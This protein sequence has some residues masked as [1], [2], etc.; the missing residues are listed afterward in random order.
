MMRL[1]FSGSFDPVT[2]GHLDLI[3]RASKIADELLVAIAVNRSKQSFFTI[4]E[5][6]EMLEKVCRDIPNVKVITIDGLLVHAIQ[7]YSVTAIL[8]GLRS[9]Q[10]FEYETQMAQANATL[11]PGC[12][13]LYLNASPQFAGISSHLVREIATWQ[14]DISQFVP[15]QIVKYFQ[16][17]QLRK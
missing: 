8:R 11:L 10:D 1:L 9:C 6:M 3:L 14:G 5:R 12:E 13:T 16:N 7:K 17:K 15:P 2:K 4:A